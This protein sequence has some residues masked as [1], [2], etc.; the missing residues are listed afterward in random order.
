MPSSRSSVDLPG[1]PDMFQ[2]PQIQVQEDWPGLWQESNIWSWPEVETD[3]SLQRPPTLVPTSACGV[4]NTLSPW[5]GEIDPMLME[6]SMLSPFQSVDS[7]PG[8]PCSGSS[9]DQ[10]TSAELQSALTVTAFDDMDLSP[11]I[12]PFQPSIHA[13]PQFDYNSLPEPAYEA[14][15]IQNTAITTPQQ[16][17]LIT[18]L[19]TVALSFSSPFTN[20]SSRSRLWSNASKKV[21]QT[22]N[23]RNTP[24]T[25]T[26]L[27]QHF[28]DLFFQNFTTS[29]LPSEKRFAAPESHQPHLYLIMIAIGAAY[30]GTPESEHFSQNL[31][32]ALRPRLTNAS[33]SRESTDGIPMIQ[34][35]ALLQAAMLNFGNRNGSR[36]PAAQRLNEALV[37][38]CRRI[39]LFEQ[40]GNLGMV[41][42]EERRRLATAVVKLDETVGVLN[43]VLPLLSDEET[44]CHDFGGKS[45]ARTPAANLRCT[46]LDWSQYN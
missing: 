45:Y 40:G 3:P 8:S 37:R 7:D 29:C 17:K 6:P 4:Q 15:Q 33:A 20:P 32:E 21:E 46:L 39:G 43:G 11:A 2:Q 36:L 23:I 1:A 42:V 24:S 26:H 44:R 27:F 12:T 25:S 18:E 30:A 19:A 35:L 16:Q 38:Q 41:E 34:S 9:V 10:W 31:L 14:P 22:F 5:T 28:L 13:P